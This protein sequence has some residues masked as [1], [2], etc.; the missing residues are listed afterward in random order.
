MWL[1][2]IHISMQVQV[3]MQVYIG[4]RGRY[5]SLLYHPLPYHLETGLTKL[6]APISLTLLAADSRP[7]SSCQPPSILSYKHLLCPG[8]WFCGSAGDSS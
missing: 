8:F 4:A 5:W 2:Y 6:E 1:Y 7:G 3:P